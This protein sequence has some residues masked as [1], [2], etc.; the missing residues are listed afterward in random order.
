MSWQFDKPLKKI[1]N[2]N[3]YNVAICT[4][5]NDFSATSYYKSIIS[6][7]IY[8]SPL[9]SSS[10]NPYTT[11][12]RK[13]INS[14]AYYPHL[15]KC[16]VKV[17]YTR[18]SSNPTSGL[19]VYTWTITKIEFEMPLPVATSGS[20]IIDANTKTKSGTVKTIT[21]YNNS[22][23]SFS[24]SATYGGVTVSGSVSLTSSGTATLY[25]L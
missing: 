2:G 5:S 22:T 24:L 8:Y 10:S 18:N 14:T 11:A 20:L 16:W 3:S 23:A 21:Q 12:Y 19:T 4:S 13:V 7:T 15:N 17:T 9:S 6:S 25:L 1:I